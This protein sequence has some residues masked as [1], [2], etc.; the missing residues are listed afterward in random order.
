MTMKKK[1]T[2]KTKKTTKKKT[3][4]KLKPVK[5]GQVFVQSELDEL[6]EERRDRCVVRARFLRPHAGGVPA[7]EDGIRAFVRYHLKLQPG[8]QEFERTVQ[9]ITHEELGAHDTAQLE[10]ELDTENVYQV[11]VIRRSDH[12]PFLLEHMIKAV[13]K[14]AASRLGV[15]SKQR[16][17]KGDVVELG[18]VLAHGDSLQNPARPW[19]IYLRKNGTSAS[20]HF[21]KLQ[22]CVNTP[23]GRK[24]IQH[25][26]EVC[27]EGTEFEFELRWLN[28][29][30]KRENIPTVIAAMTTVGI[31]SCLSLG[32]GRFEVLRLK[33]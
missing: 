5:Q 15:F 28:N 27:D 18:T 17:S 32:F 12:G 2:K 33:F 29:K 16:G 14:V 4:P 8:T 22:G 7:S 19:E 30:L 23:S 24:S 20:T 1:T 25:H 3:E 26:T 9:R 13:F 10:D 6:L 11:N 21:I 31:G